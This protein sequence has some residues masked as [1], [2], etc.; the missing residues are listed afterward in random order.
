[1]KYRKWLKDYGI[2]IWWLIMLIVAIVG[3]LITSCSPKQIVVRAVCAPCAQFFLH[4]ACYEL[5]TMEEV[6]EQEVESDD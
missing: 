6:N 2:V 3:L 5:L 1:M 4:D